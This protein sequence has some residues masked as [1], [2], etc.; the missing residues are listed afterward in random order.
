MSNKVAIF[1]GSFDPITKG[2]EDIVLRSLDLFDEIIV[3]IGVNDKKQTLFPIEKRIEFIEQTFVTK[4]KISV[5]TYSGLTVDFCKKV[6]ANFILRGIRNTQDFEYEKVIS[7][8]N[9][10]LAPE[11]ETIFLLTSPELSAIS[12]TI[13]RE[14]YNHQGD[15]SELVPTNLNMV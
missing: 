10:K 1:P 6:N 9:R 2:H 15:V 4:P 14:I 12:S 13:V 8:V 7:Q 11:V 5:D 3:A